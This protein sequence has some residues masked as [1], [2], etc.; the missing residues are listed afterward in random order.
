MS[1]RDDWYPPSR[2]RPVDGGL[3]T[4]SRRGQIGQHWWS[5]RFIDGLESIGVGG[6]LARGKRYARA[7]QV[8]ELRIETGSAIAL[9]QGS[10]PRPYRVRVGLTA[11]GKA[12]WARVEQALADDAWFA[13]KLLAGEMPPDI[14]DAFAA[15][16]LSLFPTGVRD[17][18]MDCSCPDYEVPCKHLAATL[19]LLAESFDDDPFAVLA[20][21]GRPR[22]ELLHNIG[23]RRGATAPGVTP[24]ES[25][26]VPP[27]AELLDTFYT[28]PRPPSAPSPAAVAVDSLLD[29]VPSSGIV[30][31]GRAL[32]DLLRPV[33]RA[34]GDAAATATEHPGREISDP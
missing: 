26:G 27:L 19:Y 13:A 31:R 7:G 28:A 8:I 12:E 4:R 34:L 6:R 30:V 21:R 24:V 17:L 18:A 20:L 16:G 25:P 2:P 3:R 10:R 22:D 5:V 29:Q 1:S 23:A 15:A 9:V 33:Y 32:V 14:E 11:F